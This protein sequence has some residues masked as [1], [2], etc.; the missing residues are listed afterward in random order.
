MKITAASSY[1]YILFHAMHFDGNFNLFLY[2]A[3]NQ[4]SQLRSYYQ[5]YETDCIVFSSNNTRGVYSNTGF[6]KKMFSCAESIRG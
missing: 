5:Y 2:S 6:I 1:T 3:I 4:S